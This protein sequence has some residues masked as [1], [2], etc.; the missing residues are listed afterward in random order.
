MA[1]TIIF[2]AE[3][4]GPCTIKPSISTLSSAPTG[5]RVET[6]STNP[7]V[8]VGVGVGVEVMVGVAVGVEVAVGVGVGVEV[9]LGYGVGVGVEVGLA[10]GAGLAGP[11]A[12]A[13][14]SKPDAL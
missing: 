13:T 7:G 3:P 14:P 2:L 1:R 8:E 4:T 5:S 11:A 12:L 6:F 10:V 9:G